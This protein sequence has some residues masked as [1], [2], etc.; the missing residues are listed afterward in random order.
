[1]LSFPTK[2][3]VMSMWT[4]EN[5]TSMEYDL[6]VFHCPVSINHYKEVQ[7]SFVK[8]EQETQSWRKS[9]V[10]IL[11]TCLVICISEIKAIKTINNQNKHQIYFL[12]PLACFKESLCV[13]LSSLRSSV[14]SFRPLSS[15]SRKRA[16]NLHSNKL[17]THE[18]QWCVKNP[19]HQT[20]QTETPQNS[21][22][23]C[24]LMSSHRWSLL[25][26]LEDAIQKNTVVTL[27]TAFT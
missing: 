7:Y 4:W 10:F 23:F 1:M 13:S 20:T 12:F 19:T 14:T 27:K 11:N 2:H 18:C 3:R 26:I 9:T 22:R 15:Q 17:S 8:L 25:W 24:T 21:S 16:N 5:P 6:Y